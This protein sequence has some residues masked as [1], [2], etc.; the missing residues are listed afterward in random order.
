MLNSVL[1]YNNI[2]TFYTIFNSLI[3]E[4]EQSFIK[5]YT[6]VYNSSLDNGTKMLIKIARTAM[7]ANQD[8]IRF[9]IG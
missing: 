6:N 1:E 8:W 5:N 3:D 4:D 2:I 7:S 9:H